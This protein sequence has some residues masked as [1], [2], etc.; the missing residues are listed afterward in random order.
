VRGTKTLLSLAEGLVY[1]VAQ[2][3]S[4]GV[5]TDDSWASQDSLA[6]PCA[7]TASWP[8]EAPGRVA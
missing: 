2:L 8:G 1:G 4:G 5:R 6:R 3:V 7:L